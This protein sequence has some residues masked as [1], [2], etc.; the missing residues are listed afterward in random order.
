MQSPSIPAGACEPTRINEGFRVCVVV[1]PPTAERPTGPAPGTAAYQ[2]EQCLKAVQQLVQQ[3]PD[4]S[5]MDPNSAFTAV[6]NFLVAVRKYF[7]ATAV[8]H[9]QALD[10]LNQIVVPQPPTGNGSYIGQLEALLKQ[11]AELIFIAALDCFCMALIPP[12]PP[13]PC[14]D[15]L[16]LA[17]VTVKSG[18]IVDICHYQCRKQLVTLHVLYYWLSLIGF[19]RFLRLLILGLERICCKEFNLEGFPF[20]SGRAAYQK[21]NL[22]ASG[23]T[24][25]SMANGVLATI[26][27]QHLGAALV[28]AAAPQARAVNLQ[29]LTGQ[30]TDIVNRTLLTQGFTAAQLKLQPVDADPSWTD[31]AV[32]AAAQLAPA[33]VSAGQPLTVYTKGNLVVGFDVTDPTQTRLDA[34]Q[35]QLDRIDK[36]FQSM[37]GRTSKATPPRK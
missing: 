36:Q 16:Y 37:A 15:R 30:S 27:S 31:E 13:D 24:D 19:D 23:L 35:A 2:I 5:K 18:K 21:E 22:S 29:Q 20:L 28:N 9:C 12:C 3:L 1:A 6:C 34:M 33:A 14:D 8:T 32:A 17:Q 10:D 7:A 26:L 25:P 11:I 4:I